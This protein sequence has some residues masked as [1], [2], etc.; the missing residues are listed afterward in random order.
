MSD[1]LDI[2]ILVRVINEYFWTIF[3]QVNLFV[4]SKVVNGLLKVHAN[5]LNI[6]VL[7]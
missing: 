1:S 3:N 6:F 4:S 2:L 5:I 7:K